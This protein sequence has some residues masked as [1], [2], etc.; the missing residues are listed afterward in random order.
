MVICRLCQH[1][2]PDG[3]HF[4]GKCG[5]VLVTGGEPLT[6]SSVSPASAGNAPKDAPSLIPAS[7]S[8]NPSGQDPKNGA[9]GQ[10][11]FIPKSQPEPYVAVQGPN[12]Q[13]YEAPNTIPFNH[14]DQKEYAEKLANPNKQD[15]ENV[16]VL[17]FIFGCVGFLFNPLYLVSLAA[18]VL[19]I[20]GHAN[21]GSKKTLAMLG[22]ILG[23]IALVAQIAFDLFCAAVICGWGKF[24][25]CF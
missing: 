8:S 25:F 21:N 7:G 23:L 1:E 24:L 10:S 4:C 9:E 17:A 12:S 20:I 3:T 16:S 11:E 13:T 2:N 5:N 19:G 18:I 15:Y 6:P 14:V 22:W